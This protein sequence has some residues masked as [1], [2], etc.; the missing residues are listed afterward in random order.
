MKHVIIHLI[1]QIVI[2]TGINGD[3]SLST[4]IS[5]ILANYPASEH[6]N[7]KVTFH[8]DPVDAQTGDDPI[9]E[10][11]YENTPI[12]N[13]DQTIYVRVQ[14]IKTNCVNDNLSFKIVINPLPEFSVDP[15]V[16]VCLGEHVRLEALN[17][18]AEYN[19]QWYNK[20][21]PTN[22]LSTDIF[23]N[24]TEG[25]TY[26]VKA[27]MQNGTDCDRELEIVVDESDKTYFKR[28]QYCN[29]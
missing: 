20:I 8:D 15:S 23:Y 28:R 4:K 14:N 2:L 11:Q 16:I 7:F 3:I 24:A 29:Y 27:T 5:E 26:V 9:N 19:Y 22:I 12:N 21:N 13:Q 6:G 18:L 25:G 1:L 10:N 17:P